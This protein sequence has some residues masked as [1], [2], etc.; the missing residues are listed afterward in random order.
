MRE[1]REPQALLDAI[2]DEPEAVGPWRVLADWLLE[3]GAP[4]AELAAYELK[5]EDGVRD[6]EL[7]DAI[8]VARQE[9]LQ[10]PRGVGL[11][12][13]EASWRCGYALR[14][15]VALDLRYRDLDWPAFFAAPQ[16]RLL[17][18]LQL[19]IRS[20][21]PAAQVAHA[22]E[23]V[24][25]HAP[26]T[27]RRI[28]VFSFQ[29]G[30]VTWE[31][32]GPLAQRPAKV[33]RLDLAL[34]LAGDAT[35]DAVQRL[36]DAGYPLVNLDGTFPSPEGAAALVARGGT[37]LRLGGT[38]LT[39]AVA[40]ALDGPKV[41]WCAP[42]VRAALVRDTGQLVPLSNNASRELHHPSWRRRELEPTSTCWRVVYPAPPG[43]EPLSVELQED[44]QWVMLSGGLC[45]LLLRDDL[46][47]GYREWLGDDDDPSPSR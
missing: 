6:L 37:R 19:T 24:L 4:H 40:R 36:I 11:S 29:P 20:E 27:L 38:N 26:T 25:R 8:S 34:G 35:V 30:A 32:L 2:A 47:A 10:P 16:L 41:V 44:G 21:R 18:W 13:G 1:E 23:Q 28:S 17:R 43:E 15:V 45:R 31:A 12:W 7:L 5:L 22:L 33:Q 39:R 9:R 3:H 42:D 46:D 14:L